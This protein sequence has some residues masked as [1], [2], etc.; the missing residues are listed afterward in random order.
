MVRINRAKTTQYTESS[1]LP[2]DHYL[3]VVE[4][5]ERIGQGQDV[6]MPNRDA[7]EHSNLIPDHM[8]LALHE[9]LAYHLDS[10]LFPCLDLFGSQAGKSD[11]TVPSVMRGNTL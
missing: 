8:F 3:T 4:R 9:L 1:D 10:V 6:G 5:L 7:T 11:K 2:R